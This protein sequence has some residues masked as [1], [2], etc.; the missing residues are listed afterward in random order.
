[1]ALKLDIFGVT[2]SIRALPASNDELGCQNYCSTV[3]ITNFTNAYIR[4]L[5]IFLSELEWPRA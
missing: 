3:G 1:M 2:L 4:K 5:A